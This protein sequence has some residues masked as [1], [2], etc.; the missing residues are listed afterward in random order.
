M[1][2][3][4]D[5]VTEM[6]AVS[7]G[8]YSDYQ[9]LCVCPTKADAEAVAALVNEHIQFEHAEV[10]SL[11]LITGDMEWPCRLTMQV[12]IR[13]D[14]T[15]DAK[16]DQHEK[17]PPWNELPSVEWAWDREFKAVPAGWLTVTGKDHERVRKVFS[18]RR[19]E[20]IAVESLRLRAGARGGRK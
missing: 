16:P 20:L 7:S 12:R 13:E 10:E 5:P 4:S 15:T 1:T 3:P 6:F 19:A 11:P 17:W 18:D 2:A 8:S 14:A 9:V